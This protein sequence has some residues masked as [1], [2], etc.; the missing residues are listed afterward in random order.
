M[1]IQGHCASYSHYLMEE[2]MTLQVIPP[3]H[4]INKSI[5]RLVKIGGCLH[6]YQLA[7]TVGQIKLWPL[8]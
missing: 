1:I 2:K 7:E 4:N 8:T 6:L 5:N 3:A